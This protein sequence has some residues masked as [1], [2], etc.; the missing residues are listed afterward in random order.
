MSNLPVYAAFN[1]LMQQFPGYKWE[2]LTVQ[3]K[4]E[5]PADTGTYELSIFKV[6]SELKR[7]ES[8]GWV[9]FQHGVYMSG[10]S[11]FEWNS[12]QGGTSPFLQMADLGYDVYIGNNRATDVSQGHSKHAFDSEAYW[13]F[14]IEGVAQDCLAN[15]EASYK[16]SGNK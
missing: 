16:D 2:P 11:W 3:S 4:S 1:T 13:D 15:M 7:E 14:T 12:N 6:W 5:N 10:T 8:K 9:F